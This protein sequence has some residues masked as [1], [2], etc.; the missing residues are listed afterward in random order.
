MGGGRNTHEHKV[1]CRVAVCSAIGQDNLRGTIRCL[2]DLGINSRPISPIWC[3][4][5][6]SCELAWLANLLQKSRLINKPD[7]GTVYV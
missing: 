6:G 3:P 2:T 4:P 7:N 5:C 1:N